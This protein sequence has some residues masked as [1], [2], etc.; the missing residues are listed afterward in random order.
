MW[1][2]LERSPATLAPRRAQVGRTV[3]LMA[4]VGLAACTTAET[5]SPPA[6]SD[7]GTMPPLPED[8]A[9][10][11][12]TYLSTGFTVPF[13]ITVPDGWEALAGWALGKQSTVP[14]GDGVFLTFQGPLYVPADACNWRDALVEVEPSAEAFVTA[15]T[16]Q[17]ST[18]STTPV[19]VAVGDY[20][21][22]EF[23]HS[24]KSP[25]NA[26]DCDG[27]KICVHSEEPSECTRWYSTDTER[28]TYRVVDLNGEFA[29]LTVGEFYPVDPA[30]TAE[31]R[32][33][34][35]SIGFVRTPST[36]E[37][38]SPAPTAGT[39]PS[40]STSTAGFEFVTAEPDTHGLAP[41]EQ[42]TDLV[43]GWAEDYCEMADLTPCTGI[44]DRAVPLC[45][46]KRDCHPA[47]M[48]PFDEGTAAFVSG[49][50]FPEARVL[51]V[52]RAEADP[53][54]AQYGGARKLLERYLLSVGVCP[55]D[56]G[57]S[58]QGTTC[59]LF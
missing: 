21:G 13:Q 44:E 1:T 17:T 24:A 57:A 3:A 8:S 2:S 25:I 18:V 54:L 28:E 6:T 23:D 58:P 14:D 51:A 47:L 31:A 36:D 29:V 33:I 35:D 41:V 22:L 39:I 59:R 50:I 49:G 48:V 53:A 40:N 19:E 32:T 20:P 30:L 38:G 7:T 12:G 43:A 4:C 37:G 16:A 9:L 42:S 10:E 46:E 27:D 11:D 34:F 52:W 26:N 45:I 5:P 56:K 15:L 55:Q